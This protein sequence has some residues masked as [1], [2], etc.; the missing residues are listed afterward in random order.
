MAFK[1]NMLE[2]LIRGTGTK[3]CVSQA[4]CSQ[5]SQALL[6]LT[7]VVTPYK[8]LCFCWLLLLTPVPTAVTDG[9]DEV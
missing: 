4:F 8:P 1:N 7:Q 9:I 3:Y 2:L 5:G 6:V